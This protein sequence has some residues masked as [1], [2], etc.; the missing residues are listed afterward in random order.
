[1]E[2]VA[3]NMYFLNPREL[4]Y[5]FACRQLLDKDLVLCKDLDPSRELNQNGHGIECCVHILA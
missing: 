3:D 5:Y 1:M 2:K 4:E